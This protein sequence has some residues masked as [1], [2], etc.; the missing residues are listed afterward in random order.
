MLTHKVH[1]SHKGV[2]YFQL[3]QHYNS[4]NALNVPNA[5]KQGPPI[6]KNPLM[7]MDDKN[8]KLY[9][10]ILILMGLADLLNGKLI[11]FIDAW[12]HFYE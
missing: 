8:Y 4:N 11:F 9:L 7:Q 3:N 2:R 10:A 5:N 1:Q 12:W 6:L